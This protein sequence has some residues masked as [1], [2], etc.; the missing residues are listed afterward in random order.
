[1]RKAHRRYLRQLAQGQTPLYLIS[2]LC[3]TCTEHERVKHL[4]QVIHTYDVKKLHEIMQSVSLEALQREIDALE[5][6]AD[7]L[8]R[9]F[10]EVYA[11]QT[12]SDIYERWNFPLSNT[13]WKAFAHVQDSLT[14]SV[15]V[16]EMLTTLKDGAVLEPGQIIDDGYMLPQHIPFAMCNVLQEIVD[17]LSQLFSRK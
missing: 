3:D 10:E 7:E 2:V 17:K 12:F 4:L 1:M 11:K 13:E 15:N 14:M 6:K 5:T 8:L 16:M 9:Q